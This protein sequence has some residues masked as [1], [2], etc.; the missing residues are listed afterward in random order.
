MIYEFTIKTAYNT[1][2]KIIQ[3]SKQSRRMIHPKGIRN[4]TYYKLYDLNG[5]L[6]NEYSSSV[7]GWGKAIARDVYRIQNGSVVSICCP[8]PNQ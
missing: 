1:I 6:V 3:A 2:G 5:D 4:Y 7:K 8:H